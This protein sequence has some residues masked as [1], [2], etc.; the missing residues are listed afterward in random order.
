MGFLGCALFAA[1]LLFPNLGR[2]GMW[3][4]CETAIAE[5]AEKGGEG[6]DRF[7]RIEQQ[8]ATIG[9]QM[10]GNTEV[11]SRGP[12]AALGFVTVLVLFLVILALS[13]LKLALIGTLFYI[14][15][16]FFIFHAKQLTGG[17]PPLLA[18]LLS[19]GGLAI[20]L[21]PRKSGRRWIGAFLGI[22]GLGLG[23]HVR[24]VLVGAVV[25]LLAV[26]AAYLVA[27]DESAKT[28][29]KS[30]A[31]LA[32][33]VMAA[34]A[35]LLAGL[36]FAVVYLAEGDISFI[37]GGIDSAVVKKW[38]FDFALEQIV[39][40]WYPFIALFP[41]AVLPF[42]ETE[43]SADTRPFLRALS[44]TGFLF[45]Y[46]AQVFSLDVN[47]LSPVAVGLPVA[48]GIALAIDDLTRSKRP[49]R[50][51]VF[52]SAALLTLMIRD[53]AQ[54]NQ[55]VLYGYGF[56]NINIPEKQFTHIIQAALFAIPFGLLI[57]TAFFSHSRW[58][59][60]AFRLLVP[61]TP[62]LFGGC[63]AYI[64][65]PGL[66]I[67]LSSK[68]AVE[69]YEK[70]RTDSEPLAVYG[71]SRF[72]SKAKKLKTTQEAVE[73][74]SRE[75]RAFLVFSPDKLSDLDHRL[76]KKNGKH[77]YVLDAESDRFYVATSK[78][79]P[80]EKNQNPIAPFVQSRPFDKGPQ[81]PMDVNFDD[82]LTLLGWDLD[83]DGD[84]DR[85]NKG[86]EMVFTT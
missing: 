53:F 86:K 67:Q 35:L 55:T 12:V 62:L 20:A 58:R 40:S 81:N 14:A 50:F 25:P 4:P 38:T 27:G 36:F 16:P 8:L 21:R 1:L 41:M 30:S 72:S 11:G 66:S 69:V 56:D 84:T 49:E 7:T 33:Y 18:E 44:L 64:F 10:F 6:A 9:W 83:S 65:V 75:E 29:K 26:S 77:I 32:A 63:I 13:E 48:L 68:H 79:K 31:S 19:M 45:G 76:R 2:F 5:A 70:Y 46:I 3:E 82:T 71:K 28:D 42:F 24:G 39:Y 34:A 22:V 59:A 61:L 43:S 17:M 74:L 47:G 80:N 51:L 52:I 60:R 85:L 15:A 23:C 57:V 73:W 37:T 78:P 54:N